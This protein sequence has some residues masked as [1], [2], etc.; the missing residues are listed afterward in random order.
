MAAVS[1]LFDNLLIAEN[2]LT[3]ALA[4]AFKH[5]ILNSRY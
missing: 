1:L 2:R 4:A 3:P 5:L